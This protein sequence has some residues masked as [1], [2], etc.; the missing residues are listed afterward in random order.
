MENYPR[1]SIEQEVDLESGCLYHY[2][3]G[4]YDKFY[5]HCHDYF[6]IFIVVSGKATHWVNDVTVKLPEGSLV[7]IRP[8]DIHSHMYQSEQSRQTQYINL[9]F[10][11]EVLNQLFSYL[12]YESMSQQ[13]LTCEMPPV[14]ILNK[15]EKKR[16]VSLI[17][18]LNAMHWSDKKALN[19]RLKVILSDIFTRYFFNQPNESEQ[20]DVPAWFSMLLSKM[21]HPD[22]FISGTKKMIELSNKSQE[23]LARCMKKYHNMTISEYINEQRI[24]YASNLLIKT[25]SP[26]LDICFRCGFSSVSYFYKIF[27][28]AYH[29]SPTEFRKQFTPKH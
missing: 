25:N 2:I 26:I 12:D 13:L 17:D 23:H 21:E 29:L 1:Y 11:P 6:E 20:Q 28:D 24:N 14:T 15:Y 9:T 4:M 8:D 19:L 10:T 18:E 16:I 7:F 3:Y 5:P 22:N 27:N